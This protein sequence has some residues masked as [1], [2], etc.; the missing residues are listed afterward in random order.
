MRLT[1][2][3]MIEVLRA[4]FIR[5]ARA[6]GLRPGS[7]LFK[8]ALSNAVIPVVSVAA[9][10]FGYLLGGLRRHRNDLRHERHRLSRL[11]GRLRR[12]PPGHRGVGADNW[13]CSTSILTLVRGSC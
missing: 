7:V 10:Q 13:P 2:A 6:K 3:G 11:A 4:D 1:R 12:R 8:H 5:T 9:V